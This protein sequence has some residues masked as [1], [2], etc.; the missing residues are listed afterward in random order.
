L[1]EKVQ[2]KE[3]IFPSGERTLVEIEQLS[4]LLFPPQELPNSKPATQLATS[5]K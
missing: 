3:Q 4:T 5:T 1:F 2:G